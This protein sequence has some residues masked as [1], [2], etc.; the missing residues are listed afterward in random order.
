[1]EFEL[2]IADF[3]R[4]GLGVLSERRLPCPSMCADVTDPEHLQQSGRGLR[5]SHSNVA[6]FEV[7]SNVP[8]ENQLFRQPVSIS[9]CIIF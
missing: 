8:E 9:S 2:Y 4:R 5:C 6:E 3:L 1:M 7:S